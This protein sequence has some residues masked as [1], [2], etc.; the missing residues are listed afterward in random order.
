M[1]AAVYY[2]TGTPDVL[3]YEEV[4][5]PKCAPDG[6]LIQVEAISIEGGDVGNRARGEMPKVP[7]IVG[8]QCGGTIREVGANVRDR[9]VGDRVVAIMMHGSHAELAAVPAGFA[10]GFP[11]GSR[12][13]WPLACRSRSAPPTT[14]SSSSAI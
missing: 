7:H 12:W 1:K 3:Q 10:S 2:K 8:Y 11:P 4:P 13:K 5:D 6:V 9:K 14:V